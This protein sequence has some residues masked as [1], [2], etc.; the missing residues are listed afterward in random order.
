MFNK[1]RLDLPNY[2]LLC[3]FAGTA[4]FIPEGFCHSRLHNRCIFLFPVPFAVLFWAILGVC[5]TLPIWSKICSHRAIYVDL[6]MLKHIL[7]NKSLYNLSPSSVARNY[8]TR[9]WLTISLVKLWVKVCKCWQKCACDHCSQPTLPLT[10]IAQNMRNGT[11]WVWVL[12]TSFCCKTWAITEGDYMPTHTHT[13]PMA[14]NFKRLWLKKYETTS[15]FSFFRDSWLKM[16]KTCSQ[17]YHIW[18]DDVRLSDW[19]FSILD[20]VTKSSYSQH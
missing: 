12:C 19:P 2:H 16:F 3:C 1:L 11:L 9:V 14:Q 18:E 7:C 15:P 13:H 17:Q 6:I 10:L 5:F 4:I 20:L 8:I